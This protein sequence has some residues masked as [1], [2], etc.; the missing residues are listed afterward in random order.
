[1]ISGIQTMEKI[2][3]IMD[4]VYPLISLAYHYMDNKLKGDITLKLDSENG[5]KLVE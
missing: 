1:M 4:I 2:Y 5:K 3:D